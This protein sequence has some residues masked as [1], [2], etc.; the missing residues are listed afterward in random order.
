MWNDMNF[1]RGN[2]RGNRN[3]MRNDRADT[4]WTPE[5][6][7]ASTSV[8]NTASASSRICVMHEIL[9]Y[10]CNGRRH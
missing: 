5:S 4:P 1:P 3:A 7:R 10:P 8:H 9:R 2:F 6:H